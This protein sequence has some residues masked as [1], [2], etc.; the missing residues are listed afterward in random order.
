MMGLLQER[1]GEMKNMV[2]HGRR[3]SCATE[4]PFGEISTTFTTSSN[5]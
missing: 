4:I 5:P 2:Y 1:R 3:S